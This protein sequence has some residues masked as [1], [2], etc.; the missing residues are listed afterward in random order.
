M[1]NLFD[2]LKLGAIQLPNRILMAPLT[3][4]RATPDT[5][6]PTPLQ[7]EYYT[8]RAAAGLIF[9]EA[10]SVSPMGVGYAATPGI[11]SEEQTEGWK[12]KGRA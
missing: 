6:V 5:R 3:R 8:Q 7:V 2:P 1:P 9:S 12:K 4:S 10:T 11:W